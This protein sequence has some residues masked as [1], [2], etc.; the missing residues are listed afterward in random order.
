MIKTWSVGRMIVGTV[1]DIATVGFIWLLIM[2]TVIEIVVVTS[3]Y[4]GLFGF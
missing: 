3:I 1:V 4:I 2:A